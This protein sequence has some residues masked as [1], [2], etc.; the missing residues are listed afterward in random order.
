MAT[1]P[2]KIGKYEIRGQIGRGA[3]G[4]VYEGFDPAIERRVA[5]KTLRLE[6][7]E[8]AQLAD[9]RARFK[10][11]AQAAGQLAHPHI[12]T[13]YDYGEHEGT[14]YIAMEHLSGKELR[15]VL[16]RGSRLPIPEI[17]R[18]MT[19]LLGALSYAHE[20]KVVHRDIKPANI[21][22]LDDGSLKVVDFG[23]ARVEASNLTDTGALL[24]TPAYMSPE[25]FLALPVDERSDIFSAGVILYELLTGDKPF[26]G[27]VTTVMQKVLRQEPVDP[28][29][30][31]PTLSS[32]WDAV[33]KRAMAKKPDERYRTARQFAETMKQI[34]EGNASSGLV[35]VKPAEGKAAVEQSDDTLRP[36]SVMQQNQQ[37]QP[38]S[39]PPVA[40]AG[41][42]LLASP[43]KGKGRAI[44]AIVAVFA[45]GAAIYYF[46][47]QQ[48]GSGPANPT[49][50]SRPIQKND[51]AEEKLVA[52]HSAVDREAEK[53]LAEKTG[54]EREIKDEAAAE[55]ARMDKRRRDKETAEQ[56][57]VGKAA[58]LKVTVENAAAEKARIA[59]GSSVAENKGGKS[60][61]PSCPGEFSNVTWTNCI[62]EVTNPNGIKYVGEFKDG[63]RNG[64]GTAT[65]PNGGKY[66]GDFKDG[67]RSGKGIQ[68]GPRGAIVRSGLWEDGEFVQSE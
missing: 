13:I 51:R 7:F 67:K 32:A 6:L 61:L 11:E 35:G 37:G 43:S 62:G 2:A 28:S 5:I 47:S 17:V 24:G 22:V 63:K 60:R 59:E 55:A 29:V 10:R 58:A 25:Q 53:V 42:V 19:Q 18:L 52:E 27:S 41:T 9:V 21:F 57:A 45:I 33:I 8:P 20:R 54:T 16:D 68:Y 26:S 40:D 50:A 44:G 66:V 15:H 56:P 34:V 3:M 4:V 48:A 14:P 23:I 38:A 39:Q 30:L 49:L 12:V 65:L 31:N 36:G 64:Q 46:L 1:E